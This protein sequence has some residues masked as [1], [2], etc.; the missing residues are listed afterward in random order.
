M[1]NS[2]EELRVCIKGA[3]R[4]TVNPFGGWV[5]VECLI[6]VRGNGPYG[7]V[8]RRQDGG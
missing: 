4:P 1:N 8:D 5:K 7:V 3:G 2:Y 6:G